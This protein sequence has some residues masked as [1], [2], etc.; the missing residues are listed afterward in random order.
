[1]NDI[2]FN[3]N[4]IYV[5]TGVTLSELSWFAL[6]KEIQGFEFLEDVPGSVGGAT[7]MNAGTYQDMI[8]DILS[9]VTYYS[10]KFN[11]VITEEVQKEFFGKRYPIWGERGDTILSVSFK[12]QKR[13]EDY[14]P[15]LDKILLNKKNRYMKQPR[16]YPNAGSVF[17]RPY[18]N[19]VG[20]YVWKLFEGCDLRGF[21]IGSAMI[22]EKHPGF[23]VNID[24]ATPNDILSLLDVA[25]TRV[26]SK[27]DIDLELEWKII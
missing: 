13:I 2:Y 4:T 15:I 19:G 26:K 7:I 12:V 5:E 9:T 24:N 14:E 3:Y 27:Y 18:K 20:Q 11:R 21:Q 17:K 16:D 8:G 22:S 10:K 6:E 25:Q 1:M 23:I